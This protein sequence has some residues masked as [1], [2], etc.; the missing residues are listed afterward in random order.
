MPDITPSPS[1]E[2]DW[3]AFVAIDWA[4]KKHCWKLLPAGSEKAEEGTFANTPEALCNWAT[5][6]RDRFG[7]RPVALCLEQS[8][9][10][11]VYA[12]R[13]YPYLIL[14]PI[15]PATAARYRTAFFPS[16]SKND[17]VDT[18]LLLEVLVHHRDRL[19]RLNPETS[20]TRLLQMLVEERRKLVDERTRYSNRLTSWL[21]MYFP[22]ALDWVDNIDSPMGCD[23]LE[24]WPDLG[25]LQRVNPAK[26]RDFF[27]QH[28]CRS[29]KRIQE[30]INAIYQAMPAV[31]DTALIAAGSA[32]VKALVGM[33]KSLN[34]SIGEFDKR[35]EEVS[36]TH[37]EA[38][39]FAKLPGAGAALRPRLIVAFGTQRERY[40]GADEIQTYSGI[41]PVTV[42]SGKSKHVH[43][44][45]ARPKFLHQTFYEFA[46]H[47]IPRC[48]W[49]R[50]Y[51][52]HMREI[53]SDHPAAVRALAFK[54]IRVLYACWRDGKP[55]DDAT[56]ARA[57]EKRHSP[58]AQILAQTEWKN[59]AGFKKLSLKKL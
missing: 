22:Q 2:P 21:K 32:S 4:D 8:R 3:A 7:G 18:E 40:Q 37:A 27:T 47:S 6:L 34:S 31:D 35:I 14:F 11:L 54:W 12:L 50:A 55:Y 19:R 10:S 44:R 5:N 41:A 16:G 42:A 38:P 59:V 9:G 58:L 29:H 49:A 13:R 24:R 45:R 15:H 57:L 1:P 17:P 25:K 20:E 43:F 26:L 53:G 36:S 48:P 46:A 33:I 23:L 39:L 28:N 56:Y 52:Q 51:Y 30:R